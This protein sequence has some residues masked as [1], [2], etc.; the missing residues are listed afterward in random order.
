MVSFA[1][2]LMNLNRTFMNLNRTLLCAG[3]LSASLLGSKAQTATVTV[4]NYVTVI[5][6]NTVTVT[7]IVPPAPPAVAEA[8]VA[9]GVPP[10][11]AITPKYPWQSSVSVGFSMA[12]GN[13]QSLLFTADFLTER[14]TPFNEYK[15]GL[16]GAYGDQ[17]SKETVN[18]YKALGQWNHLF[19]ERFFGYVRA[20]AVRDIIAE[21]DYRFTVGPGVGYYLIKSTNTT[22]ALEA[23]GAFEAQKLNGKDTETF[24][25]IRGAERFEHKVNDHVRIWQ[26][27]EIMPEV[28]K[29]DN[30]IVNFEIGIE[31]M[32]TKSFSLKT[33]LDDSYNNRP[34]VGKL[35]NDAKIV[36]ALGYKF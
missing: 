28:D 1:P 8:A 24:A 17:D 15:V 36:A 9:A 10:A 13:S 19:T 16:S 32:L 4:T 25:T 11:P 30:Y 29:F 2:F 27:V 26:S 35:K 34:A 7:N 18:N 23:G 21:V 31:A 33:Y 5:V 12:R 22:L 3:I 6:T 14:K 20:D